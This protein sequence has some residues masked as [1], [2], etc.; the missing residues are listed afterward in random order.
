MTDA[1]LRVLY[2]FPAASA[3]AQTGAL[4]RAAAP[5]GAT[6][7]AEAIALEQSVELP[8]AAVPVQVASQAIVGHVESITE[9]EP[10]IHDAW[11][12]YPVAN[13]GN[14][15]AQLLNALFGNT[16]LQQDVTLADIELPPALLA[17]FAG[18]HFGIAGLRTLLDAPQGPLTCT[19]LKPLGLD[20]AALAALCSRF[21]RAGIQIIKD[22]HSI[23]NQAYAPFAQ[24]VPLCAEAARR[25]AEETGRPVLYAPHLTGAPTALREQMA[26]AQDA[27]LRLVMVAPM[28]VGLPAFAELVAAFPQMAFLAH[29]ALGGAWRITPEL[30]FGKLFRLAGADAVI[31]VSHGGRFGYTAAQCRA[32]AQALRA[33]WGNLPPAFPVPSGGMTVER[34]PELLDFYGADTVLLVSGDLFGGLPAES[35]ATLD[36]RTRALVQVARQNSLSSHATM[37]GGDIP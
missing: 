3:V 13:V 29:P 33:P 6:A 9:V 8:R 27:G 22:D 18:A 10:G 16:S 1:R 5:D 4:A 24:R 31:F 23:G 30:L 37:Q 36:A 35:S 7:R 25:V 12:S 20:A 17:N 34:V 15:F 19:A 2:R 26:Q 21:A 11:I 32:L 14:S 28:L